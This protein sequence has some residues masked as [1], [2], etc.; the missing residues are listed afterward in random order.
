M[1]NIWGVYSP[2]MPLKQCRYRKKGCDR[3]WLSRLFNSIYVECWQETK[4]AWV[5][6]SGRPKKRGRR[7]WQWS[8]WVR[9]HKSDCRAAKA[10]LIGDRVADRTSRPVNCRLMRHMLR[11]LLKVMG[12]KM[13]RVRDDWRR[14]TWEGPADAP[15][16]SG[17]TLPFFP[18]RSWS[19]GRIVK[20]S[21]IV[22]E[23]TPVT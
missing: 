3:D 19:A 13:P 2:V 12:T 5:C 9:Q 1:L 7:V 15:A 10:G 21:E 14:A 16:T 11:T 17:V 22:G 20:C 4:F 6:R 8:R 18:V 23:G